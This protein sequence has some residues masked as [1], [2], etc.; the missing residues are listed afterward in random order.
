MS[1]MTTLTG[2]LPTTADDPTRSAWLASLRSRRGRELLCGRSSGPHAVE[3]RFCH[4]GQWRGLA[5]RNGQLAIVHRAAVELNAVI[6][7]TSM[8]QTCPSLYSRSRDRSCRGNFGSTPEFFDRRQVRFRARFSQ[9]SH[10][11]PPQP[12]LSFGPDSHV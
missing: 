7:W 8:C 11:P 10:R 2:N 12:Y 3:R 6:A 4:L 1:S 9:H 5:S